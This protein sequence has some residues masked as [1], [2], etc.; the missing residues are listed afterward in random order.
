MGEP[1][2]PGPE[3]DHNQPPPDPQ[4][5]GVPHRPRGGSGRAGPQ[6]G[7]AD[8]HRDR[9]GNGRVCQ[10]RARTGPW[11][12]GPRGPGGWP[13]SR[14][15]N[16]SQCQRMWF[17]LRAHR[18]ADSGGTWLSVS[19]GR[20]YVLRGWLWPAGSPGHR[21]IIRPVAARPRLH[22]CFGPNSHDPGAR[23]PRSPCDE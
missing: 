12:S 11:P 17:S 23:A 5:T 7:N 9:V 1:P 20:L 18:V 10:G 15:R 16:R 19:A 14:I 22:G 4:S 8:R 2:H 6:R 3:S 21:R 13:R